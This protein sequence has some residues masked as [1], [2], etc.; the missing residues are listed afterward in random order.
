MSH[1]PGL[2][3]TGTDTGVGKT[4]VTAGL[5]AALR[6]AGLDV[7]VMKPVASGCGRS[8]IPGFES[9]VLSSGSRD[10]VHGTRNP[11]RGTRD[12][13]L[14]SEDSVALLRAARSVDPPG[15]VTPFA[16]APPVSPDQAARLARRPVRLPAI[17]SAFRALAARHD[18]M[19]VEGVGGLLVPLGP[20]LLVADVAKRLGLP[21]L[22]VARAG[23]GTL[24]HT[25]LTL[26]AARRRGLAVAGVVLNRAVPGRA[27]LPER[28]NPETLRRTAGVPV[29]GPLPF[30]AGPGAFRRLAAALGLA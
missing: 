16:Y 7:G 23:L 12:P 4:H 29:W 11:G 6:A 2:F 17:V 24:N 13:G 10:A 30:R 14:L 20:R 21:L 1:P 3:I 5:A 22:V 27:G 19:L 28:M 25:R 18:V 9:R 8:R 26:E 15:L